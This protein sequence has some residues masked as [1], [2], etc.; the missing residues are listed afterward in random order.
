MLQGSKVQFQLMDVQCASLNFV[1]R[2]S[3]KRMLQGTYRIAS[4]KF[5]YLQDV[6]GFA[7]HATTVIMNFNIMNWIVLENFQEK[8]LTK[9]AVKELFWE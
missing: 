9:P 6:L 1:Q 8:K 4:K 5:Q 7:Q 2:L 3:P